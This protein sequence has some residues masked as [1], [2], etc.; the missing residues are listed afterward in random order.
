MASEI[1]V[2]CPTFSV[3]EDVIDPE[4]A[5]IVEAPTPSPVA[6][7]PAAIVATVVEEELQLTELV[8]FWV[9]PSL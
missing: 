5:A 8:R 1:K 2:G 4:V 9:L 7:P 6:N 3:V